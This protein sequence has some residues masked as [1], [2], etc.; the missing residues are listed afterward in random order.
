MI[1]EVG[2][3]SSEFEPACVGSEGVGDDF[4]ISSGQEGVGLESRV[5]AGNGEGQLSD[6][7]LEG[8]EAAVT[9]LDCQPVD[10]GVD[11]AVL[12][13]G[14]LAVVDSAAE[15]ELGIQVNNPPIV[16]NKRTLAVGGHTEVLIGHAYFGSSLEEHSAAVDFIPW[17]SGTADHINEH[18]VAGFVEGT[19]LIRGHS[20]SINP[21]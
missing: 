4:R 13:E 2:D 3:D 17:G 15:G 11:D 16:F 20:Q 9:D 5:S 21:D 1:V 18:V 12:I 14:L 19:L 6:V 10:G 7:G 8:D